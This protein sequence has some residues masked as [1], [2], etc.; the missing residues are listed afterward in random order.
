MEAGFA[1]P[2]A[3]EA[4]VAAALVG[5]RV[6][7]FE[8]AGFHRKDFQHSEAERAGGF[9]FADSQGNWPR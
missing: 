7:D 8:R 6:H 4:E 9:W 3:A 1:E 2:L 5:E